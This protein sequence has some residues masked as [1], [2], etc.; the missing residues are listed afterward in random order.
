MSGV[1]VSILPAEWASDVLT[2]VRSEAAEPVAPVS[3]VS[4]ETAGAI[5]PL[6]PAQQG[7]SDREGIRS[8]FRITSHAIARFRQRCVPRMSAAE[9]RGYLMA[10]LERAHFVK[11]LGEGVEQWRGPKPLRLRIRVRD[12]VVITVM[13]C[14]DGWKDATR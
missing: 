7:S 8:A 4:Q 11:M 2:R 3:G 1:R 13:P 6:V 5:R 10:Q 14:C 12:G 9:A